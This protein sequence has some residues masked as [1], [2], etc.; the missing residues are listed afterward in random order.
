MKS[1]N[2]KKASST[3]TRVLIILFVLCLVIGLID[4]I[5]NNNW[6][7]FYGCLVGFGLIG[8]LG[9]IYGAI[10]IIIVRRFTYEKTVDAIFKTPDP[11]TLKWWRI[12]SLL[13][14]YGAKSIPGKESRSRFELNG[15]IITFH[16]PDSQKEARS[17]QVKDIRR[18]V[19]MQR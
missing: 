2:L 1:I 4:G 8:L 7:V 14:G 19:E 17:Y 12:K 9:A 13:T 10:E 15:V 5:R 16:R 3:L 18:F 6:D 11:V